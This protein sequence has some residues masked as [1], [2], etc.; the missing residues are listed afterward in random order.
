M[1]YEKVHIVTISNMK[2]SI[3]LILQHHAMQDRI[4]KNKIFVNSVEIDC[5][6]F[7]ILEALSKK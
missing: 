7:D 3:H 5:V 6:V 1:V 4:E 2:K